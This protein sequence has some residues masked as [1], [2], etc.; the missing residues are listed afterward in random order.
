MRRSGIAFSDFQIVQALGADGNGLTILLNTTI[1]LL[2]C[3]FV[4]RYSLWRV[5]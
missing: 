1:V 3:F 2:D 4:F 5:R